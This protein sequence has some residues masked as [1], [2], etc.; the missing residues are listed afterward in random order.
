MQR[1]ASIVGIT[2]VVAILVVSQFRDRGPEDH[3]QFEAAMAQ[4]K[5]EGKCLFLAFTGS[6]W[7]GWCV[8][9]DQEVFSQKAFKDFAKDHLVLVIADFPRDK[10]RQGAGLQKQNKHLAERFGVRG[11]PSVF[12]LD[13]AGRIIAKTGYRAGGSEAYVEEV[14]KLIADAR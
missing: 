13:P 10:S 7:C 4:A 12:I 2:V 11:F 3:A 6:D 5:A 9:L 1:L 14:E 8:K